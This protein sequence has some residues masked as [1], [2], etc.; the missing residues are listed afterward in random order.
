[1][2]SDDEDRPV[3][4]TTSLVLR[5]HVL[6]V[7]RRI[8]TVEGW[9]VAAVVIGG[10]PDAPGAVDDGLVAVCAGPGAAAAIAPLTTGAEVIVH[11]RLAVRRGG[12]PADDA[13][14]LVADALLVRRAPVA[15]P[16]PAPEPR[17]AP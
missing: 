17:I 11:G 2:R 14:E 15:S 10:R 12:R 16:E 3:G 5:G 4:I 13:V 9:E 7:P 1:V 6:R 8:R